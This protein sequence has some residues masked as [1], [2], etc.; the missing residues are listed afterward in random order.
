[1]LSQAYGSFSFVL[2][3]HLPYVIAHGK[4]PHGMDWLNEAAA[5]T[6]IP[7]LNVLNEMVEEGLQPK[8]TIGI[9]PILTE[10]L[11]D[12]AFKSEF[13][14][15][16]QNKIE[17]AIED[18]KQFEKYGQAHMVKLAKMWQDYYTKIKVDFE[19]KYHY[20]IVGA[21][22][23]LLDDGYLDILTCGA[24]HGYFPLLSQDISIQAQVKM[25]VK[26][27]KRHYGRQP[28]G[29]WLPECAYRPRYKWAP[30]VESNVGT[31]P[32]P[33]KGVDEFLSENGLEY[34][35]VDSHLLKGGKAI[36]VYIDRFDALKRL[37]AQYEKEF[38]Y[39]TQEEDFEKTP[40]ELY[41]V[42]SSPEG[43]KPVAIFTRDPKTGLQVWSGE[44]GY[45]G[46]GW[47]LDFHKK[48]FPGGHR[49]WRI[50]SA[51]SDLADKEPYDPKIPPQRIK[52]NADHFVWLVKTI[53][54]ER[55][56]A[57]GSQGMLTAPFDAELFGH[58]WFE[59]PAFLKLVLSKMAS[60]PEI[61]LST[62]TEVLDKKQPTQVISLPE[63]SWGEGG[64]HFIWL[65]ENTSWTWKH[66]YND[67]LRM[68]KL[69]QALGGKKDGKLQDI[70]K[71]AARELLLLQSS[72]W[73]FLISTWAA[74]DYAELRF[75]K[76]DNDF[77]RLADMA[78]EYAKSG[79]LDDGSWKLL[80]DVKARDK[81]FPD[82]ELDW[83]KGMEFPAD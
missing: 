52:E 57:T 19:V 15:Y 67:E 38:E 37:W 28:R 59:G 62:C 80:E 41:L 17:A 26:A 65:N 4:W 70:L 51:K 47:Y 24:T 18:L 36:G 53:L 43:K 69:A 64:H 1:M 58:W 82:I 46:D 14:S 72:D 76:H 5:E 56:E 50:T 25:A 22:R 39:T 77:N 44:H 8:L 30:P 20:D 68:Q 48:H 35:I 10:Q 83:F 6:Y 74:R 45:P 42:S 40:Y 3:S 55:Y 9:T 81:I 2:H 54:R 34:F 21:Y 33:R 49:Y 75:Q 66:I 23:E 12:E 16:L 29:I 61:E 31:K 11:A 71:Q 32:Y 13:L 79:K 78:E 60:D 73:Q 27:H 63:G 7:I